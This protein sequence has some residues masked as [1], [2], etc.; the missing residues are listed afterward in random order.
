MYAPV[1]NGVYLFS[2][3]R[4]KGHTQGHTVEQV[5]C[6]LLPEMLFFLFF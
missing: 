2:Q 3:I 1:R 4:A 5:V 6:S